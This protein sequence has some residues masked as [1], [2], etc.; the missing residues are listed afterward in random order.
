MNSPAIRLPTEERQE[1]IVLAVISLAAGLPPESLTTQAIATEIG[2][3]QGALFRHFASKENLWTAVM[4]WIQKELF[5]RLGTAAGTG[6]NP[7]QKLHA[8]FMAHVNFVAEYPGVPRLIFNELQKPAQTPSKERVRGILMA[9]QRFL[10]PLLRAID[11]RNEK[12]DA[13]AAAALFM[14]AIQGLVMQAMLNDR[15]QQIKKSAQT[16][17]PYLW[18]GLEQA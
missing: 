5:D 6:G 14:G 13:Q 16:I 12:Y 11:S 2:L 8:V 15:P 18:R 17:F 10:L 3:T 4:D 9:Y 1:E 7:E